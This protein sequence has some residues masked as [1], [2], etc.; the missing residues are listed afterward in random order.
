MAP[1]SS[2]RM[3]TGCASRTTRSTALRAGVGGD[4]GASRAN[5]TRSSRSS[6][7]CWACTTKAGI[8]SAASRSVRTHIATARHGFAG[9]RT[10]LEVAGGIAVA[11]HLHSSATASRVCFDRRD[12]FRLVRVDADDL[13]RDYAVVAVE[14]YD[15]RERPRSDTARRRASCHRSEANRVFARGHPFGSSSV[16]LRAGNGARPARA[17]RDR[18]RRL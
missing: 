8:R 18:P 16:R 14:P 10:L 12:V 9:T 2:R 11:A 5:A 3:V 13:G 4:T 15:P 7:E 17:D 6:T 1:S